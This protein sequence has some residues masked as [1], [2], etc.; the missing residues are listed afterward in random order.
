MDKNLFNVGDEVCI[1]ERYSCIISDKD[2]AGA[3]YYHCKKDEKYVISHITH[4]PG[5]D[6][7]RK[8]IYFFKEF[9]GYGIYEFALDSVKQIERNKKLQ[10]LLYENI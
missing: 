10:E 3:G 5:S 1:K 4:Y 8:Y 9:E 7:G 6:K 2:Y